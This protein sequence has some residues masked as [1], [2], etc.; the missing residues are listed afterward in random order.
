AALPASVTTVSSSVNP[1]I[2]GQL[3]IFTAV[4]SAPSFQGTPTGSVT[5]TIDGQT[6]LPVT[7]SVFGGVDEA[8]F[9]TST[10]AAGQHNVTA[11]YSGD[12]NVSPST[13]SLPT[14]T[15]NGP[16]LPPTTTTPVSSLNPA[17]AGQPA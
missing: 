14:Q 11:T 1:S 4:V 8:Q 6:E 9:Y 17:P 16:N 3:V 12:T 10:L 15:V 2:P 5:F 7:L 13:Q